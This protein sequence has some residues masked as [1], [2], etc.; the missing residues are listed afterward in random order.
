MA[1]GPLKIDCGSGF[2]KFEYK[3]FT[4]HTYFLKRAYGVKKKIKIYLDKNGWK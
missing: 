1:P 2:Y 4:P 3:N